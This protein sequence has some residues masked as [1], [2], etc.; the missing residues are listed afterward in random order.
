MEYIFLGCTVAFSACQN[1]LCAAYN[2][3]T[4]GNVGATLP[5]TFLLI[6]SAFL[7]WVAAFAVDMQVSTDVIGY[8]AL[9][10][11]CFTV[12]HWGLANALRVGPIAITSLI[13]Q[14]SLIGATVWGFVFWNA[15][16]SVYML[17]G[18]C[19]VGGAL[20][21]CLKGKSN[22][23][24]RTV[25]F[26]WLF[27]VLFAFA[28]NAGCTIVQKTQQ[29][30]S[31]G[32]YGAFCMLLAVGLSAL[33]NGVGLLKKKNTANWKCLKGNW[34]FPV[35]AGA[36]NGLLNLFAI[37]LAAGTLSPG[38]IYPVI[39]VGSLAMTTVCSSFIFHEK[40]STRQW[41]GV[42]IGAVGV[43]FLSI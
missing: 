36:C 6:G 43:A 5:Y 17:I 34:I 35:F 31:E 33:A 28:A 13:V 25:S 22:K 18:L 38:L 40:M 9:F 29:L 21:L 27:Y 3:R 14:L 4:A 20:W 15:A 2:R 8:S 37:R 26:A 10:A 24:E 23:E 19:L 41:I 1:I 16:F 11:L 30:H 32:K 39:A 42:A 7:C 12:A